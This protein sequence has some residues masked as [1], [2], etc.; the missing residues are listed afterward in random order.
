MPPKSLSA[1]TNASVALYRDTL[2]FLSG[3]SVG[4]VFGANVTIHFVGQTFLAS[5]TEWTIPVTLDPAEGS[6]I[7]LLK[8]WE[9]LHCIASLKFVVSNF[10]IEA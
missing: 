10:C 6:S 3:K 2:I 5:T 9:R 1:E 8:N 7:T 4:N